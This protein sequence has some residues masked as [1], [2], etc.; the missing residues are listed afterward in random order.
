MEY[1]QNTYDVIFPQSN[2]AFLACKEG[3]L[4]GACGIEDD[5]KVIKYYINPYIFTPDTPVL[6]IV[7]RIFRISIHEVT[8]GFLY[9]IDKN[10]YDLRKNIHPEEFIILIDEVSDFF[11]D[12][13]E[14][15]KSVW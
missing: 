1:Y 3:N 15:L 8:H 9:L 5:N 14:L 13:Q 7:S 11:Y 4:Y 12:I 10:L 6:Q 2:Y